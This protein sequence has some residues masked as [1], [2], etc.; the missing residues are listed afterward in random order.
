MTFRTPLWTQ[1][2]SHDAAVLRQFVGST[3][4]DGVPGGADLAVTQRGAGANMSVDVAP[5]RVIVDDYI[6]WSDAIVNLVIGAPPGA[7]QQ[8]IDSVQATVTD[9]N[10][11]SGAWAVTVVPGVSSGSPSAPA[12]PSNA[13]ELARVTLSSST[14]SITSGNIADRRPSSVKPPYRGSLPS[15]GLEGQI[16]SLPGGLIAVRSSGTWITHTLANQ[17]PKTSGSPGSTVTTSSSS[18]TI[19]ITGFSTEVVGLRVTVSAEVQVSIVGSGLRSM[20]MG[21][22]LTGGAWSGAPVIGP[23]HP[24]VLAS[25]GMGLAS[26]TFQLYGNMPPPTGGEQAQLRWSGLSGGTVRF[27]DPY[28][29][30]SSFPASPL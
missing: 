23:T 15:T 9:D 12:V 14:T 21:V 26:M 28:V 27:T 7:G 17:W 18:G 8:R 29:L 11:G 25:G 19:D 3:L 24:L 22:R 20:D 16:I 2:A 13:V 6:C 1:G 4:V 10:S 5:G 30:V